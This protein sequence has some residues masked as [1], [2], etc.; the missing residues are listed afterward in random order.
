MKN[1]TPLQQQVYD[2]RHTGMLI[3]DIATAMGITSERVRQLVA[4]AEY[5]MEKM[6]GETHEN[7]I[8]L[9]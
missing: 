7:T 4:R 3:K 9:G 5:K 8:L 2:L 6:K 1:L